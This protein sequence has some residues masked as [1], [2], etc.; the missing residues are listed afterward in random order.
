MN[1]NWVDSK[2]VAAMLPFLFLASIESTPA[3]EALLFQSR[4]SNIMQGQG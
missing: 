3:R 2:T 4:V 1:Q